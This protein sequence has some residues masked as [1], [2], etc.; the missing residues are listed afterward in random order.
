[1]S[2]F[3]SS[4]VYKLLKLQNALMIIGKTRWVRWINRYDIMIEY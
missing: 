1:M 2:A 4:F 3:A